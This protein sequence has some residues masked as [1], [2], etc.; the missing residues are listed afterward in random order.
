MHYPLGQDLLRKLFQH[1]HYL[2]ILYRQQ[3]L[4]DFLEPIRLDCL[5][6]R[7]LWLTIII[8]KV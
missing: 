6:E 2:P 7:K 3:A 5:V 1:F 4:G 8:I